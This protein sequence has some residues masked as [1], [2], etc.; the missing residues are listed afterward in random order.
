MQY[1]DTFKMYDLVFE[2]A[3]LGRLGRLSFVGLDCLMEL[4]YVE[5][6]G[7]QNGVVVIYPAVLKIILDRSAA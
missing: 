1:R 4:Q 7:I 3:A 6:E 5:V 2:K